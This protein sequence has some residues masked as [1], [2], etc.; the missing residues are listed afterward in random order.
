MELRRTLWLVSAMAWACVAAAPL[1][2][3]HG[4]LGAQGM[5]VV[6][7]IGI[8]VGASS[9]AVAALSTVIAPLQEAFRLGYNA[10]WHAG[11]RA[12]VPRVVRLPVDHL[13][14]RQN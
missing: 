7:S 1:L 11:R 3:A 5:F 10:G 2:E 13:S 4:D 12:H 9:G 14:T 6:L 8:G